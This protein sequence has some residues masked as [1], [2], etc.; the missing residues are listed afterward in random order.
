[1]V[2]AVLSINAIAASRV[3]SPAMQALQ[4]VQLNLIAA[5]IGLLLGFVSGMLMGLKFHEPQWLGGYASYQRRMIRLGHIS[6]FGLAMVNLMF[7]LAAQALPP[8]KLSVFVASWLF[9]SGAVTMPICCGLMLLGPRWRHS[10]AIPVLSLITG[11][12]LTLS[13]IIKL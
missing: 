12:T 6:F 11:A 4:S 9:V 10:F 3:I 7:Y 5:W 2:R 8:A 1:M 13:E